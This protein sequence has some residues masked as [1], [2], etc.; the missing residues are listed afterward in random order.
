MGFLSFLATLFA[1]IRNQWNSS[2][3]ALLIIK[4]IVFI[5]A[6]TFMILNS[7][8][9]LAQPAS[10]PQCLLDLSHEVTT[11]INKWLSENEGSKNA[12]IIV[13]SLFVD[14][15]V[16]INAIAWIIYGKNLRL[17]FAVVTFFAFKIFLQ[18]VFY[19]RVPDGYLWSYPGFPSLTV[20]YY[21][22]DDFFFSAEIGLCMIALLDFRSRK[23]TLM[24]FF[25]AFTIVLE[26]FVFISTRAHYIIDLTTGVVAGH[27]FYWVGSWIDDAWRKR[28]RRNGFNGVDDKREAEESKPFLA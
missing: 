23:M 3:R 17:V 5:V 10:V 28:S 1:P 6:Y 24:K 21:T 9:N 27:Y 12:L 14:I 7:A 13:S 16:V 20:P 25:A 4:T 15:T 2:K 22:A 19:F 8:M 11:P 18:E 26:C